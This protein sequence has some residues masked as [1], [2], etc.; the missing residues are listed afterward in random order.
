MSFGLNVASFCSLAGSTTGD[1]VPDSS[2]GP[3]HSAPM[4]LEAPSMSLEY[5]LD[6]G[7]SGPPKVPLALY[8]ATSI[9]GLCAES[10]LDD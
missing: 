9:G 5:M 6:L 1:S 10:S 2:S 3:E 8:L 7:S 4:L